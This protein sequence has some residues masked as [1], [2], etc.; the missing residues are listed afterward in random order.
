[1]I[2]S[3]LLTCT[4]GRHSLLERS[5][6]LFLAQET[7]YPCTQVIFNNSDVPLVLHL[8]EG[9]PSNLKVRLV[10]SCNKNYNNL[11]EIYNDALNHIPSGGIVNHYD[12][13]DVILPNHVEEGIKGLEITFGYQAYKPQFSY[14]LYN[15]EVTKVG[16][17]MEPSIFLYTNVLKWLGYHSTTSDQHLKWVNYLTDNNLLYVDP[18]GEPTLVYE[19]GNSV[20]TFKTSGNPTNPQNFNNYRAFSQDHGDGIITPWSKE[21]VKSL[22]SS[23]KLPQ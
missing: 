8:P 13:D 3:Y 17:T 19:W 23:L 9:T 14:Y 12:D 20:P 16:N 18:E 1:M 22:L 15:N 6:G 5:V 4:C 21:R 11:G 2:E 7:K 10:N